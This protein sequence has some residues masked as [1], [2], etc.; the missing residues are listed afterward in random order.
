MLQ[1]NVK[2]LWITFFFTSI[3]TP[4]T[5]RTKQK[6][7]CHNFVNL[8][9]KTWNEHIAT[10][11]PSYL[12]KPPSQPL[13]FWGMI[14]QALH[15]RILQLSA[16][17]LLTSSPLKLCQVGWGQ[18]H[19]FRFLQKYLIGCKLRLWLGH[20]RTFTELSITHSCCVFRGRC[21][22]GRWTF[23]PVWGSKCSGLGFH[24]GYLNILV[25]WAFLLLWP[26]VFSCVFTQERIASGHTSITPRSVECCS[27]VCPSVDFSHLHIW[28][29]SS[30]R[31]TIRFL[32]TSLFHQLLSLARRPA[33]GRVLVVLNFF[34]WG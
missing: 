11:N 1:P 28:S 29:W 19:I 2:L 21:P 14:R 15:I 31:V 16:I 26:G 13:V 25:C 27:D 5:I 4:Y 20:S 30:A 7:N 23:C 24:L 33:L 32:V 34:H 9:K 3:Y 6:E 22:V 12:A 10:L 8:Y 17:V 18:T